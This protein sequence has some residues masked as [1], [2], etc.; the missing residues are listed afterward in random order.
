MQEEQGG[1]SEAEGLWTRQ[2]GLRMVTS[3]PGIKETLIGHSVEPSAVATAP[4]RCSA[5]T[6]FILKQQ[7][8]CD[9]RQCRASRCDEPCCVSC[10][11]AE[12]HAESDCRECAL[13]VVTWRGDCLDRSCRVCL[14]SHSFDST[15]LNRRTGVVDPR[16]SITRT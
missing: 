1:R 9:R 15:R 10:I 6:L 7:V 8:D 11:L 16:V 3:S 14:R 5:H 4:P 2:G 12:R 13:C